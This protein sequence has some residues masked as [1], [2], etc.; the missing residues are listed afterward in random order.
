M[1]R[2]PVALVGLVVLVAAAAGPGLAASGVADAQ[3]VTLTVSVVTPDGDPVSGATLDATWSGGST[4][5]TTASNGKAFVDVPPDANVTVRVAHP[6]YVRND[7]FVVEAASERDVEIAVAAKGSLTVA[8]TDDSGPVEQAAVVVRRNGDDVAS[9]WTGA[10]GTFDAGVV[11]QRTY[12]VEVVKRGYHRNRTTV[13]VDGDVR[14]PVG[15]RTG[16]VVVTFAVADDHFDPAKPVP[17]AT[18][19]VQDVGTFNT[20]DSGE[21]TARVPVN[22]VL[23]LSATK[24]A[25]GSV[26]RTL[27]TGESDL[28]VNFTIGRSPLVNLSLTSGRVVAG[29]RVRVEVTDEY[30]DPV[31]GATVRL[32][33]EAAGETNADGEFSVPV[34]D[35]GN[36]TLRAEMGDLA[37]AEKTVQAISDQPATTATTTEAPTT[38]ATTSATTTTTESG[39]LPG[40]T[41]GAAL[42]ALLVAVVVATRLR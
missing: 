42:L 23:D 3:Q 6:D 21:A 32:D 40:F 22:A 26:S 41:A 25:Y 28:A 4:T 13:D 1:S 12:D 18:I 33:G 16:S 19:S 9:G 36:H 20:L 11:E 7:P 37:S 29:E 17:G 24:A 5:A 10:D 14:H 34:A 31:G 2:A 15:V 38:A 39:G 35:P 27:R 8:V 30:G